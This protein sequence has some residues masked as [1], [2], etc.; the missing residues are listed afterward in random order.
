M[1][2]ALS[3][4]KHHPLHD[5]CI[6]TQKR[7]IY[8][9]TDSLDQRELKT[10][11]AVWIFTLKVNI[12]QVP[13]KEWS[14]FSDKM[15]LNNVTVAKGIIDSVYQYLCWDHKMTIASKAVGIV[16]STLCEQ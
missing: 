12:S 5:H 11:L 3:T 16:Q 7:E 13:V 14:V 6:Y 4:E 8:S 2:K 10:I 15:V 1:L 9:K